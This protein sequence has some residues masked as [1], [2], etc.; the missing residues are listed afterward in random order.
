MT[1]FLKIFKPNLRNIEY[2]KK[3]GKEEYYINILFVYDDYKVNYEFESM[4][5]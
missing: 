2:E 3:E 5:S 1:K 4:G